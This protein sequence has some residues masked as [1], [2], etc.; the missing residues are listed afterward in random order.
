MLPQVRTFLTI[1]GPPSPR[2]VANGA[3]AYLAYQLYALP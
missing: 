1:A 2:G 3:A